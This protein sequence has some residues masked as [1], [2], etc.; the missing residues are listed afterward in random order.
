MRAF[1]QEYDLH[2]AV[3]EAE[4]ARRDVILMTL[5]IGVYGT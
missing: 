4:D 2:P 5:K 1:L 3:F